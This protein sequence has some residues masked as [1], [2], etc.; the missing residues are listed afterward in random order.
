MKKKK[1]KWIEVDKVIHA[2][3]EIPYE[4]K[5]IDRIMK[6]KPNFDKSKEK[7]DEK[8]MKVKKHHSL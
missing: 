8:I 2:T 5:E 4:L 7:G 6:S 3:I 1:K